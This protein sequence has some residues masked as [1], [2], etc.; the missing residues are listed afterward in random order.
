MISYYG[1]INLG[2][3]PEEFSLQDDLNGKGVYISEWRSDKPQPSVE[4]IEQADKAY[5]AEAIAKTASKK[6][7]RETALKKLVEVAG[8]TAEEA[9]ELVKS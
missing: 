8:L 5:I 1:L 7:I 6:A 2:F 3:S 4:E 9:N